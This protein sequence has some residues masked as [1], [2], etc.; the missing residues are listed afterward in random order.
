MIGMNGSA[1]Y[2]DID[3]AV[4]VVVTRNRFSAGDFTTV[5]RMD[6]VIADELS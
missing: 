4:A 5:A 3:S 6:Q 2:A 1:T